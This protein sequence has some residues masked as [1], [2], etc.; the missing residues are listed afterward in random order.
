[1]VQIDYRMREQGWAHAVLEIG[2]IDLAIAWLKKQKE[3]MLKKGR[4]HDFLF[5]FSDEELD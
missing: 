4:T 1:M 2:D 5:D 3:K